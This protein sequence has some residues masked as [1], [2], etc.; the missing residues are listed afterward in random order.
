MD[1]H[2]GEGAPA[3]ILGDAGE[4]VV[5][6]QLGAVGGGDDEGGAGE[7]IAEQVAEDLDEDD[8][9]ASDT[10]EDAGPHRV[11]SREVLN[12]GR[13][14][15]SS[16]SDEDETVEYQE[17]VRQYNARGMSGAYYSFCNLKTWIAY[18]G[19]DL[20][21]LIRAHC[22]VSLVPG[23]T[24]E[25]TA[26]IKITTPVYLIGNNATLV[27]AAQMATAIN[28][29]ARMNQAPVLLMGRNVLMGLSMTVKVGQ[30]CKYLVKSNIPG[31]ISG[32]K[33]RNASG[34]CVRG[35]MGMEVNGCKFES[36]YGGIMMPNT[37]CTLASR[38]CVFKSNLFGISSF[39][40]LE[41]KNVTFI[42]NACSLLVRGTGTIRCCDFFGSMS[43]QPVCLCNP[44][45]QQLCS[46]YVAPCRKHY[47]RIFDCKFVNTQVMIGD[48]PLSTLFK[49]CL[50]MNSILYVDDHSLSKLQ[51]PY[52]MESNIRI[53][54]V[55][56]QVGEEQ[57]MRCVCGMQ[58]TC[59][60][61]MASDITKKITP[62]RSLFSVDMYTFSS[63][64]E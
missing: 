59:G 63:D 62:D 21:Q 42:E 15:T 29:E 24:Y 51:L 39:S 53:K 11:M 52:S 49:Q 50:I 26:P 4:H 22:K 60:S 2:D 46:V 5:D 10:D 55:S 16:S 56:A 41:L 61:V 37:C 36:S 20:E 35:D 43:G 28:I 31:L 32:C 19:D 58:H 25:L 48:R 3:A 13:G 34:W 45:R 47:P 33:M 1:H 44:H 27:V 14:R 40:K 64:E 17:V 23:A 18:P 9:Y 7:A 38:S 8:A 57:M 30:K 6:Q 12:Y 54:R